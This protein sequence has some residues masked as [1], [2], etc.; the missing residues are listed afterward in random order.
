[1]RALVALVHVE[2]FEPFGPGSLWFLALGLVIGGVLGLLLYRKFGW[3]LRGRK[4]AGGVIAGS[5][6]HA[7]SLALLSAFLA[8]PALAQDLKLAPEKPATVWTVDV[9]GGPSTSGVGDEVKPYV[10]GR[11]TVFADPS[12]NWQIFGRGE[13]QRTP[14]GGDAFSIETLKTFAS[15]EGLVGARWRI[16]GSPYFSLGA[17]A[18]ASFSRE[19]DIKSPRDPRLYTAEGL[20]CGERFKFWPAGGLACLGVGHRG[21]AGGG[22]VS[23][24]IAQPLGGPVLLTV[25]ADVPF[26]QLPEFIRALPGAATSA[27]LTGPPTPE[28]IRGIAQ[29]LPIAVRV[30]VLVRVSGWKF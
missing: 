24:S 13:I 18:G 6:S 29:R 20:L 1:M 21:P 2:E 12:I 11:V 14:N 3:W 9:L 4:R 8:L 16:K 5:T 25:D 23:L 27:P 10:T 26:N 28:Q 15:V 17:V 22:A 30:G 7:F 19:S